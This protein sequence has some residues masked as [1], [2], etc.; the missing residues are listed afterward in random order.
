MARTEKHP[1]KIKPPKPGAE[2]AIKRAGNDDYEITGGRSDCNHDFWHYNHADRCK[3][4][5]AVR[6]KKNR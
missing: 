3:H 1:R 4:C 2:H 6:T 5:G